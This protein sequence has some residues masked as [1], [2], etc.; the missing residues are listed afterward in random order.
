MQTNGSFRVLICKYLAN[1]EGKVVRNI[2]REH[3]ALGV[4]GKGT[5]VLRYTVTS[6]SPAASRPGRF[7]FASRLSPLL[8][9]ATERCYYVGLT[10]L[11]LILRRGQLI[12]TI[13]HSFTVAITSLRSGASVVHLA[14]PC[15]CFTFWPFVDR[16]WKLYLH[17]TRAFENTAGR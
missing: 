6:S 11:R 13:S 7:V 14:L 15:S 17:C 1:W 4:V 8:S 10:N 12:F 3:W 9:T 5:E 16:G 2:I